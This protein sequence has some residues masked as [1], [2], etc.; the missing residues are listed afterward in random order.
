[1]KHIEPSSSKPKK[2]LTR[3]RR[4]KGKPSEGNLRE[5]VNNPPPFP[6]ASSEEEESNLSAPFTN[7]SWPNSKENLVSVEDTNS[8]EMHLKDSQE[9]FPIRK[10]AKMKTTS[11]RNISETTGN[12]THRNNSINSASINGRQDKSSILPHLTS[13]GGGSGSGSI[14]TSA[15][16][17]SSNDL[18][19]SISFLTKDKLRSDT[20]DLL[21]QE[22]SSSTIIID[23]DKDDDDDTKARQ[24]KILHL[25]DAQ[26]HQNDYGS[27]SKSK[28][29]RSRRS[30]GANNNSPLSNDK[31]TP[32]SSSSG[33]SQIYKFHPT[34]LV[35]TTSPP[36]LSPSNKSISSSSSNSIT[37]TTTKLPP[38]STS[39]SS[40]SYSNNNKLDNN[41]YFSNN[42]GREVTQP[43]SSSSD[44]Y[45][46]STPSSFNSDL[47][48]KTSSGNVMIS[49]SELYPSPTIRGL[50]IR[51]AS[52]KNNNGR[53]ES[54]S[55]SS[56]ISTSS[57][58]SEDTTTTTFGGVNSRRITNSNSN[59]TSNRFCRIVQSGG[60]DGETNSQHSLCCDAPHYV[61]YSWILCMVSLAAFLKLYFLVKAGIILVFA[62][63]YLVLIF[64][65]FNHLFEDVARMNNDA[66]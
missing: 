34:S 59:I 35:N 46:T 61:V 53:G 43:T 14:P 44:P 4:S 48:P 50:S 22:K 37:I 11:R 29:L 8:L 12:E 23:D 39:R 49:S 21:H 64:F 9:R 60:G 28:I 42:R 27:I 33:L 65:P 54:S 5:S 13:G 36:S 38:A 20:N 57:S 56:V 2:S 24:T 18:L 40:N 41:R 51:E 3:H 52:N 10:E 25:N 19:L 6:L 47:V 15:T 16:S 30:N 31:V 62:F 26:T 32:S 55:S 58:S 17:P 45:Y 66:G 1:M 7:Q 63:T